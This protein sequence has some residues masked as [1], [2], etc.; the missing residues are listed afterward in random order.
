M[1]IPLSNFENIIDPTI[2]KR[3]FNYFNNGAISDFTEISI[4]VYD[5]II[6]GTEEYTVNLEVKNNIVVFHNCDC[7]Y[8]YGPV[9]KHIT[10][11]IFHLHQDVFTID[12]S[13]EEQPKKKK[14]KSASLQ[15]KTLLKV[16]SHNELKQFIQEKSKSDRKFKNTFLSEFAY[17]NTDQNKASYQKQIKDIL[18]TAKGRDGW[19]D[20]SNMKY[21]V[22]TTHPFLTNAEKYF[23]SNNFDNAFY[24]STALLEEFTDAFQFADDS[25]GDLGFF[26][27]SALELLYNLTNE[28]LSKSLKNEFFNYCISAYKKKLFSGW[29][30]H[31]GMLHIASEI[32]GNEKEAGIILQCLDEIKEEYEQERAQFLK[33]KLLRKFKEEKV[34]EDY[35]EK[36]LSNSS[37]RE[38]EIKKAFEATDFE[39]AIKLSKE[40]ISYDKNKRPGLVK[41]WYNWLLEIAQAEKDTAKIIEYA[42]YLFIDSFYPKHDYYK[43]LKTTIKPEDWHPFLEGLI[44]EITPTKTQW[45]YTELLRKIYIEEE[46]WDRLFLM[47]KQNVSLDNIE[48]NEKYLSQN[49]K[50][51]LLELYTERISNYVEKNVGRN[52]YKTACRYLRRMKKLGGQKQVN[53]LIESF[54]IKYKQR[55]ALM[56]ELSRV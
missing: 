52:H 43:I 15:I 55:K 30:W 35:I 50:S 31:L 53:T 5:A 9:C 17:L 28:K 4:G 44:I 16:I 54:Q 37:I 7:P 47:L 6:S 51:E 36:H 14:P 27:D 42:R 23:E 22:N 12:I 25:N 1:N 24:I 41:K 32:V 38:E 39:R 34:V 13:T 29:D 18:Y 49:Y 33:L 26:I 48:Q 2:L 21:M 11:A 20:W 46:W 8:D 19:I 3:G 10:A 40:G 56:D 45:T